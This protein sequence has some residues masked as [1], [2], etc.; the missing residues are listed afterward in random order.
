M[1]ADSQ[2]AKPSTSK[3]RLTT[4][5]LPIWRLSALALI[6]F[7]VHAHRTKL[8][9]ESG[10]PV[11]AAEVR[12]Y[13]PAARDLKLDEDKFG[14]DVLDASGQELGY[15]LRTSPVCNR[16]T[17]Y[18]GPTDTLIAFSPDWKV[19]GVRIR[20]SADTIT[21]V[22]D[23]SNDPTFL[24]TWDG[25]ARKDVAVMDV[26][27][28]GIEG[29]SGATLTSM[30]VAYGI[31]A[32]AKAE[33]GQSVVP[34]Q[35]MRFGMRDAGLLAVLATALLIAFTPARGRK[36]LRRLFQATVIGYVGFIN[37]DLLA[38]SLMHGWTISGTAWRMAPGAALMLAAALLVPWT[39]RRPLYCQYLCPHGAA[40]E[41]LD[42]ISP[43]QLR[44]H[45]HPALT[46]GLHWLPFLLL[47]LALGVT[48][49][50]LPLDLAGIE[51]FDAY[52]LRSAG[53][54][55]LTIA[56]L[57]L[58]ASLFVPMAY[59]KFGCPTGAVFEFLRSHGR[60]DSFGKR[61]VA[62][63]FLVLWTGALMWQ[64]ETIWRWIAGV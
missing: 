33:R 64:H 1:A 9:I 51:P 12:A 20:G 6:V 58:L 48:M 2:M 36:W 28:A 40:Q 46:R 18:S 45:L 25:M 13:Y 38:Q 44:I 29:V 37:G 49:L 30:A 42:R 41:L 26:Q 27:K 8:A 3:L 55:T 31:I 53:W 43:K 21:H 5:L 14:L 47:A 22:A 39:T 11:T 4:F 52:L 7:L 50:V 24:K 57:G 32:R 19:L 62:A 60:N 63:A 17:G 56:G 35:P 15:V 54:A 34:P 16:I 61:D 59:C 23:I 10:Q